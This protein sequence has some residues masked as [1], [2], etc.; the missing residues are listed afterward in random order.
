M[1]GA[2]PAGAYKPFCF[3]VL[4]AARGDRGPGVSDGSTRRLEARKSP[5]KR[6]FQI[7][8]TLPDI[9]ANAGRRNR[10]PISPRSRNRARTS[11]RCDPQTEARRP[12]A[13]SLGP[14]AEPADSCATEVEAGAVNLLGVKNGD[15]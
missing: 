9:K 3:N 10:P 4:P 5:L 1:P 14:G 6:K 15:P 11:D 2:I 8:D 13:T 12:P 7:P